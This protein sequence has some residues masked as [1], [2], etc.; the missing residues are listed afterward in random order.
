MRKR[1]TYSTGFK[2]KTVLEALQERETIQEIARKYE[3]LN[4]SLL[5]TWV[6]HESPHPGLGDG[7]H[8]YSVRG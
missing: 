5:A 4:F 7:H 6:E 2:T 3:L 8:L 1:K